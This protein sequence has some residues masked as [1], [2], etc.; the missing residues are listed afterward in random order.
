LSEQE[1]IIKPVT[2]ICVETSLEFA[3]VSPV[4]VLLGH[5]MG[6]VS[7]KCHRVGPKLGKQQASQE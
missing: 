1:V 6:P 5:R 3:K 7:W 4:L 2:T